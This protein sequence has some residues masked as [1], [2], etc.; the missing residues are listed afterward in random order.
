MTFIGIC[1]LEKIKHKKYSCPKIALKNKLIAKKLRV[2]FYY[3]LE[4]KASCM[5]VFWWGA[6]CNPYAIAEYWR[7]TLARSMQKR[8]RYWREEDEICCSAE[9]RPNLLFCAC[10]RAFSNLWLQN[11]YMNI[12]LNTCTFNYLF[13]DGHSPG[14]QAGAQSWTV[15][16]KHEHFKCPNSWKSQWKNILVIMQITEHTALQSVPQIKRRSAVKPAGHIHL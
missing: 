16:A 15:S 14:K 4:I 3:T 6:F 5:L 7:F 10:E 13:A 1:S 11:T 8:K 9:G 2:G 12:H